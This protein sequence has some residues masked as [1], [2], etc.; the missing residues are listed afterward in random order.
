MLFE[1]HKLS[2]VYCSYVQKYILEKLLKN[3]GRN[4]PNYQC[5]PFEMLSINHILR[6]YF[7]LPN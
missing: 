7:S 3:V 6:L 1:R 5:L 4:S 2:S